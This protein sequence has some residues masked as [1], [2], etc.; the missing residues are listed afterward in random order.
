MANQA[1]TWRKDFPVAAFSFI[2]C[3]FANYYD[4]K[5][6]RPIYRTTN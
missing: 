5:D 4:S 6:A 1:L 2:I 3:L